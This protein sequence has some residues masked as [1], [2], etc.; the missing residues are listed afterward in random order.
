MIQTR[1]RKKLGAKKGHKVPGRLQS[2]GFTGHAKYP[3]EVKR[4]TRT[5]SCPPLEPQ[6]KQGR[7]ET[8]P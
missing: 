1:V 5:M 7:D 8:A 3:V 4:G 2:W 6:K